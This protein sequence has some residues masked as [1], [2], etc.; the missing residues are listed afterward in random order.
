MQK[1]DRFELHKE[2]IEFL[3]SKYADVP[4]VQQVLALEDNL[5]FVIPVDLGIAFWDWLDTESVMTMTRDY[6]P[7]DDTYT[8]EGIID[9]MHWQEQQTAN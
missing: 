9:Y 2:Q 8:I 7:T 4:L 3:R 6:E 5:H 1:E